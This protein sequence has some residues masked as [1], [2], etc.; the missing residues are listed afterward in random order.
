MSRTNLAQQV[1]FALKQWSLRTRTTIYRAS[2]SDRLGIPGLCRSAPVFQIRVHNHHR[3]IHKLASRLLIKIGLS[4]RPQV[5]PNAATADNSPDESKF[6]HALRREGR[7]E[8]TWSRSATFL[9]PK[10]SKPPQRNDL[11]HRA[12]TKPGAIQVNIQL[13]LLIQIRA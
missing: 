4:I 2:L 5:A 6:D 12:S 7:C 10:L 13:Y 3:H 1:R 9:L 11:S 8:S